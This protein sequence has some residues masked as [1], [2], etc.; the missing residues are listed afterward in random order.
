MERETPTIN[1]E[2]LI[3]RPES[4]EVIRHLIENV[5]KPQFQVPVEHE[6]LQNQSFRNQN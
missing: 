1:R 2:D 6:E 4:Q 3:K 5:V